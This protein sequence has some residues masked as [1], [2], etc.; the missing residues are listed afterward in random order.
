MWLKKA[1]VFSSFFFYCQPQSASLNWKLRLCRYVEKH[2][3]HGYWTTTASSVDL[4]QAD[5]PNYILTEKLP[6]FP[7]PLKTK[8]KKKKRSRG[9]EEFNEG[10]QK[11]QTS[12]SKIHQL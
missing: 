8:K 12:S 10:S 1:T 5:T 3:L 2:R 6:L 11:V 9:D 4:M 7:K